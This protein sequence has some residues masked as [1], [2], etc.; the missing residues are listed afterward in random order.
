MNFNIMKKE[1]QNLI[2]NLSNKNLL[3]DK[4]TNRMRKKVML[5]FIFA[6]CIA[7]ISAQEAM[8]DDDIPRIMEV[9]SFISSLKSSDQTARRA[10][11]SSENV[12]KLLYSIQPSV[13][14]QSG[15]V[16]TYGERPTNLFMNI[17]SM[18]GLTDSR[19][20]KNNIEIV[21]I[22]IN[23]SNELNSFIDLS[24]FSSFKNLKYIQITSNVPA[25]ETVFSSMVQNF[26]AKYS[27]FY[28]I[29]KGDYN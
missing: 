13:Y 17:S 12:E 18:N 22:K 1:T 7:N 21:T 6:F 9:K 5:L 15:D 3:F 27:V 10:Y 20:L 29:N 2:I 14:L 19:I 23:N 28:S 8:L 25:S 11:S 26:N 24:L 4:L 16:T